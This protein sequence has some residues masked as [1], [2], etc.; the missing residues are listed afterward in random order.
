[1]TDRHQV[2]P[3][4]SPFPFPDEDIFAE[5]RCGNGRHADITM[6]SGIILAWHLFQS[7]SFLKEFPVDRQ[8]SK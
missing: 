6:Y 2:C 1:M 7:L 8:K 5:N 4:E 3:L